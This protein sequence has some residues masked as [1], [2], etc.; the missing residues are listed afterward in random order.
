MKK[1]MLLAVLFGFL[2][3]L[4]G[5]WLSYVLGLPSGATIVL[6]GGTV[7]ATSLGLSRVRERYRQTGNAA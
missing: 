4:G 2:F 5:L 7:L 6:F 3:T 1:M